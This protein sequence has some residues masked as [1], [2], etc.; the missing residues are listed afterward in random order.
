EKFRGEGRAEALGEGDLVRSGFE[1]AQPSLQ[2]SGYMIEADT[3][4]PDGRFVLPSRVGHDH[5][6]IRSIEHRSDPRR[7]LA[8]EADV[9]AAGQVRSRKFVGVTRVEDLRAIGLHV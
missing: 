2:I 1:A 7:V 8:A 9:D 3:T 6:R 5:D 4:Q